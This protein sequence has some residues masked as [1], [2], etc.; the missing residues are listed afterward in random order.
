MINNIKAI[1]IKFNKYADFLIKAFTK[2]NLDEHSIILLAK[3][4]KRFMS[5]THKTILQIIFKILEKSSDVKYNFDENV[6]DTNIMIDNIFE[7]INNSLNNLL[8]NNLSK[9]QEGE[10]KDIVTDLEFVKKLVGNL[11]EMAL[12]VLKFESDIIREDEF[13]DN[14]KKFKTNMENNKNEFEKIVN[15]KIRF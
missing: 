6:L 4:T 9:N 10:V 7:A 14:Y 13:K 12:S 1:F 3:L 11:I 15:S 5:F 2:N 8:K